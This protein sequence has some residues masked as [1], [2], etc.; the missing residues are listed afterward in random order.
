MTEADGDDG[1]GREDVVALPIAEREG[2]EQVV[3]RGDDVGVA[4]GGNLSRFSE[5][6]GTARRGARVREH[7]GKMLRQVQMSGNTENDH[8]APS[9]GERSTFAM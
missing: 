2:R 9:L 4:V 1:P 3:V 5:T 8:G 6:D 7:T